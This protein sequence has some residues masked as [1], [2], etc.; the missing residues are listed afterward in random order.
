MRRVFPEKGDPVWIDLHNPTPEE[1]QEA[2]TACGLTIPTRESL[3]EIETSSRLQAWPNV[4]L[5]SLPVTPHQ[6]DGAPVS[7]PIGLMLS[8]ETLVTVRFDEMLTFRQVREQ[9]ESETAPCSE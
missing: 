4:L 8:P 5:I 2:H 1:I 9:I 7:S 3:D 6:P